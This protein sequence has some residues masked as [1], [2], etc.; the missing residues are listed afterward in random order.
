MACQ[1]AAK[2]GLRFAHRGRLPAKR[3]CQ[4]NLSVIPLGALASRGRFWLKYMIGL[5]FAPFYSSG[6]QH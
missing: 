6:E 2:D 1:L 5:T 3:A 4:T